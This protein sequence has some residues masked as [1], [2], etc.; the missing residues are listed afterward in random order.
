MPVVHSL[1]NMPSVVVVV[2]VMVNSTAGSCTDL[3]T[4]RL[5]RAAEAA[6]VMSVS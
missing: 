2:E 4:S 1:G 6:K 3:M 5:D